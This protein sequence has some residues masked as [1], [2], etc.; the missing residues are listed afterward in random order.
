MRLVGKSQRVWAAAVKTSRNASDPVFVSVGHKISLETAINTVVS[1]SVNRVPEPIRL[2]DI[3]S[4]AMI[5]EYNKSFFKLE[6]EV[7]KYQM[8]FKRN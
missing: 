6:G 4:R 2:A 1:V 3:K 8:V 7:K 5:R